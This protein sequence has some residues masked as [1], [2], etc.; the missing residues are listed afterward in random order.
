MI[1]PRAEIE[2][3]ALAALAPHLAVLCLAGEVDRRGLAAAGLT[4]W[5]AEG[6]AAPGRPPSSG[7]RRRCT[8][9]GFKVGEVM[10]RARQRGSSPPVAEELAAAEAHAELLPKDLVPRR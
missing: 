4:C 9:P 8:P 2:A 6:T 5:P 3:A 10:A 1:G 7:R